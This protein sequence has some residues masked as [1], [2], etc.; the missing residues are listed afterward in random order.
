MP[1]PV[2]TR[3]R[4]DPT[5]LLPKE[6]DEF[7]GYKVFEILAEVIQDKEARGL[8]D[9]WVRNYQLT[10]NRHWKRR[11]AARGVNL[12]SANLLFTHR[13]RTVNLLTDN[14]PTFNVRKL[15]RANEDTKTFQTLVHATESWWRD[16]EQQS[17]L[18][19]SVS[20]GETYGVTIEK[21]HFD[22]ELQFGMGEVAC[23]LVDPFYFGI[24]PINKKDNQKA[25]ANLHFFPM[26]VRDVKRLWPEKAEEV[27][28]DSEYIEELGDTRNEIS[29]GRGS[30]ASLLTTFA[31]M[32]KTL[33][34]NAGKGVGQME[35]EVLVC[36]M[37]VKDYTVIQEKYPVLETR[38]GE[39]GR[40][41]D[42]HVEDENG[43][44]LFEVIET[45]KYP[46][47]VR[48]VWACNGGKVVLDDR[49][50]PNINP[51]LPS[52]LAMQTYLWDRFP[53]SMTQSV[54][55]TH[56]PWGM[57]DLEQLD[58]LNM[59]I[60]KSLSQF[61]MLKDK[62]A[63]LKLMNPKDTGV[64]NEEFDN[65]PGIINPT[66]T[67]VAQ[68]IKY[69]D[70]PTIPPDIIA[71]LE[72][73]KDLFMLVAGTFDL[74]QAKQE[75]K[76]VIA[77]KAIAALLERASTM[78][79][80]KIRN[81]S[82]MIRE[83]GRMYLSHVMNWYTEERWISY[84]VNGED[85]EEPIRGNMLI[86]P[87]KLTVVNGSTMPISK[88][89]ER[90]ESLALFQMGAIDQEEL[91]K[92]IE[93]PDFRQVLQRMQ[94][95]PLNA[96]L[97]RLMELGTPEEIAQY[98]Q[99]LSTMDDAAYTKA[100]K[101]GKIPDFNDVLRSALKQQPPPTKEDVEIQKTAAEAEKTRAETV[102]TLKKAQTE[103]VEQ[104][105]KKRGVDFDEKKLR[106]EEAETIASIQERMERL[107]NDVEKYLLDAKVKI[108]TAK[109]KGTETGGKP[110]ATKSANKKS[111][112]SYRERGLKS[113]NKR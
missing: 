29:K 50:N 108:E 83:R 31:N 45:P 113:N 89:Q 104:E 42:V 90:E 24:Y 1:A 32:V 60:N 66:N 46:G 17:I 65:I 71:A 88:V 70:P 91:L 76:E 41:V 3:E 23:D 52:E 2:S 111:Q 43:D 102:L 73:Y 81:Y 82:K 13:Q 85:V 5:E 49:P 106:L 9:K 62:A 69:M 74:D 44:K 21:T 35:D 64:K 78:L 30:D 33:L 51:D 14:N 19:D 84:D 101:E 96:V 27:V 72:I 57:S 47:Y 54:T 61:T 93:W 95:G 86:L 53:F 16:E 34:N 7:V 109:Q 97:Q 68:G 28:A 77:Y 10:R 110:K 20:N 107:Q 15:G 6:G 98:I 92:K 26:S 67:M 105:V 55:D 63:R 22:P 25:D 99:Q 4:R 12:V 94:M 58:A 11:P 112:G 37:W 80:G 75:G 79:R 87:A 36:E 38:P 56:D 40:P 8:P 18:E 48:T 100:V 39:D 103:M 59:E